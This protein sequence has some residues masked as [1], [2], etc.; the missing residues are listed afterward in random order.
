MGLGGH[1]HAPVTLS[2]VGPRPGLDGYGKSRL[3]W[4]SIVGPSSPQR[5][6]IPTVEE[7]GLYLNTEVMFRRQTLVRKLF[8][9]Q[10]ILSFDKR[11]G[12]SWFFFFFSSTTL[13][14]FWLAQLFPSIVS[15]LAPSIFISSLPSFSGN[16]SRHLPILTLAFLFALCFHFFTS[17]FLRSFLASSSHLNLGLPFRLVAYGFHLY[18]VRSYS[19]VWH[20]FY[21]PQP[22]QPFA[23]NVSYYIFIT[24]CV[25]QFLICFES[26]L[27]I[28]LDFL[29]SGRNPLCGVGLRNENKFEMVCKYMW[30]GNMD[31]TQLTYKVSIRRLLWRR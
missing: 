18:M 10:W 24:N 15:S 6:A 13:Y 29:I 25:F 14:E 7:H 22:V 11:R 1:R 5:V 16:F 3:H 17:I 20:S 23:F 2:W 31:W 26:P 27:S 28:C 19:F 30:F 9:W 4:D 21:M 12:I 8:R